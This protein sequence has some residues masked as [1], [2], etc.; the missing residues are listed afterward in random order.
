MFLVLSPVV[1][2]DLIDG[3]STRK[4]KNK[5]KIKKS[6]TE[7]CRKKLKPLRQNDQKPYGKS[8]WANNVWDKLRIYLTGLWATGKFLFAITVQPAILQ[9]KQN[10]NN[11]VW[12]SQVVYL[13]TEL[14]PTKSFPFPS[15]KPQDCC[16][17]LTVL[18]LYKDPKRQ[19]HSKLW[20][21]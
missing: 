17:I 20:Y 7:E 1:E 5:E 10:D 3:A 16:F 9:E 12:T 21:C 18:V 15:Q 14:Q 19:I 8:S 13:K 11:F 4:T 6:Y 2:S